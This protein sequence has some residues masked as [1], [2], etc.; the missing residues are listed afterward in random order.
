V[1]GRFTITAR[2]TWYTPGTLPTDPPDEH[3]RWFE[4]VHFRL[5][6]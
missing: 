2:L 3:R 4:P 1:Q 6:R 5:H